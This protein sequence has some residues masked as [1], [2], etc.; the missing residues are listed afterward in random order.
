[1]ALIRYR[2]RLPVPLPKGKVVW[3]A[4]HLTHTHIYTQL[5]LATQPC[6]QESCMSSLPWCPFSFP[7]P[8]VDCCESSCLLPWHAVH[9]ANDVAL[10]KGVPALRRS[11]QH[12]HISKLP[13]PN[14]PHLHDEDM[15]AD[16]PFN[17]SCL[18]LYPAC[19][20]CGGHSW[21]ANRPHPHEGMQPWRA[22]FLQADTLSLLSCCRLRWP[23]L[24]G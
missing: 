17:S 4:Q 22:L 19:T 14:S 3:P 7:V 5:L 12:A 9:G 20:G 21:P 10:H 24:A 8:A 11:L 2:C 13:F 18:E 6:L 16:D 23:L 1:M 15:I